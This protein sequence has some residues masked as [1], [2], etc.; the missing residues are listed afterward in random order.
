MLQMYW[1]KEEVTV[2]CK[3]IK[4]YYTMELHSNLPELFS[5]YYEQS[6]YLADVVCLAVR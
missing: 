1:I 2:L 4:S 5:S 6:Y 3:D